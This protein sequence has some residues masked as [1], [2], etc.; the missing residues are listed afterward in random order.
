VDPTVAEVVLISK[1]I[2]FVEQQMHSNTV[3]VE[4]PLF[5][6]EFEIG[7]AIAFPEDLEDV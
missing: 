3:L 7:D 2:A 1:V 5:F 4:V 6:F